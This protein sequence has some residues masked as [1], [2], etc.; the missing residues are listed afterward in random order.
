MTRYKRRNATDEEVCAYAASNYVAH[1]AIGGQARLINGD[2]LL[3]INPEISVPRKKERK[4]AFTELRNTTQDDGKRA[5]QRL[6][7]FAFVGLTDQW[8]ATICLFHAMVGG[9]EHDFDYDNVR[10]GNYQEKRVDCEDAAD[11][12]VYRCAVDIFVTNL[13]RHPQ[14]MSHLFA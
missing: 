9:T 13:Q 2:K 4:F 6:R 7:T 1:T 12:E 14:C 5:C 11:E 3:H 8:R 10:K